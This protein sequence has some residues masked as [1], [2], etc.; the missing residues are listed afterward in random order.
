MVINDDLVGGKT[1]YPSEN[2]GLRQMGWWNSQLFL[3]SQS[4]FHGSSQHQPV[5]GLMMIRHWNNLGD[6]WGF[7]GEFHQE[8]K[9]ICLPL[10]Q[11]GAPQ[12]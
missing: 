10:M 6:I 11:D 2:Y 5:I 3:E 1:T 12:L 4:T 7:H 9:G 8:F